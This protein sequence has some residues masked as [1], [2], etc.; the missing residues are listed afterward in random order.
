MNAV[1]GRASPTL[2]PSFTLEFCASSQP[3]RRRPIKSHFDEKAPSVEVAG[4]HVGTRFGT[5]AFCDGSR[6]RSGWFAD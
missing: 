3:G 2:N 4:S 1:E 6:S 5:K